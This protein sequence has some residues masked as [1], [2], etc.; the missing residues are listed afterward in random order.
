MKFLRKFIKEKLWVFQ[1]IKDK[2]MDIMFLPINESPEKL[3][4]IN[5]PFIKNDYLNY[6]F[7]RYCKSH[8]DPMSFKYNMMSSLFILGP[9]NSGKSLFI[10]F[11]LKV[12]YEEMKKKVIYTN[13]GKNPISLYF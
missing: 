2:F 11:N 5:T 10:D 12:F 8:K 1:I 7:K 13:S 3:V 9:E 4:E 6:F